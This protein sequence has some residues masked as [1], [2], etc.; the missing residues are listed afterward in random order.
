MQT[1]CGWIVHCPYGLWL[2]YQKLFGNA[3]TCLFVMGNSAKQHSELLSLPADR[4]RLFHI[5]SNFTFFQVPGF[6]FEA[7]VLQHYSTSFQDTILYFLKAVN[8]I[9]RW[10]AVYCCS[11]LKSSCNVHRQSHIIHFIR[12]GRGKSVPPICHC[13]YAASQLDSR[14]VPV[15]H[16]E[17]TSHS[18]SCIK[19]CWKN[20]D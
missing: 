1:F 19:C 17:S 4:V 12:G 20:G 13:L 7:Q 14:S 5:S 8:S 18:S 2:V 15:C 6:V 9:T 10:F 3:V 11:Y 16:S